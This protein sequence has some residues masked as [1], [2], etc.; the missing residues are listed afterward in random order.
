LWSIIEHIEET[1]N[2]SSRRVNETSIYEYDIMC[3]SHLKG[4]DHHK[5]DDTSNQQICSCDNLAD[6][7]TKSLPSIILKQLIQKIGLHRLRDE[8]LIEGE[9]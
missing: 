9:I 6:F 1:C 5:N 2:L 7:F 3:I 8:C 4:Y